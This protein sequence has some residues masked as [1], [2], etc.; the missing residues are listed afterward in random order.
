MRARIFKHLDRIRSSFWFIPI[1]M[2]C[3]T[4]GLA[5]MTIALDEAGTFQSLQTLG[6]TFTGG[7]E[8]ASTVLGTIAGSMITIVG[9]VFSMTLLTLSLASSQFGPRLLR[10]FMRD[11]TYQLVLGTFVSTFLYCLLVLRTI[12]RV[13]DASFVPHL[14]VTLGVL[15]AIMSLGVLIYFIHHVSVSIQADQIVARIGTELN[16]EIERLFPPQIGQGG[17][18]TADAP[19]AARFLETLAREARPVNSTRDGYLQFID[20]DALM[21]LA[22]QANIVLQLELRPGH[23]V[24]AGRP[25]V[26]VWPGNRTVE[27]LAERIAAAFAFGS[28]RTPGQDVEFAIDQLV[29]IAVRAL[30]PGINDPFTAISCVDRLGSALCRVARREI[31]SP[32][33]HDDQGQLRVVAPAVTFAEIADAAF[34]Q[35]RHHARSSATVTLHLLKTIGVIAQFTCRPDDRAALRQHAENIAHGACKGLLEDDE[36]RAVEARY[37]AAILLLGEQSAGVRGQPCRGRYVDRQRP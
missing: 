14:S 36:Q 7:A 12:R 28:Q 19:P 5:V 27:G 2:T 13:E 31:P 10:N 33:R 20:A 35:I 26:R 9:V 25:L 16:A 1:V 22:T 17:P 21:A 34:K 11:T 3:G 4:A 32:Y 15:F 8:G 23:Y 24:V 18:R 6:W 37:Q 29:E 30:S